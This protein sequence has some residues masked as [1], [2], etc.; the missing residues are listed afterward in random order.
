MTAARP[1]IAI[2]VETSTGETFHYEFQSDRVSIGRSALADVRLPE[3]AISSLHAVIEKMDAAVF[4]VDLGSTNGT[5]L[6]GARLAKERRTALRPDDE[7]TIG[8]FRLRARVV[9]HSNDLTSR[10]ATNLYARRMV[11]SALSRAE[12]DRDAT[13]TIVN[14]PQAG[15]RFLLSG[16]RSEWFLG[17]E[18]SCE[19]PVIDETASRHHAT[20]VSRNG[21]HWVVDVGAKNAVTV[22]RTRV[23]G[24]QRLRDRDEIE[25]GRTRIVFE[26]PSEGLLVAMSSVVDD[27]APD[28]EK[29][30]EPVREIPADDNATPTIQPEPG[31]NNTTRNMKLGATKPDAAA[32][33]RV[34]SRTE[35]I[36]LTLIAA[37]FLVALALTAIVFFGL[38]V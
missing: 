7:V 18:E 23:V 24:E 37:G 13:L 10:D 35:R 2:D 3:T 8:S 38:R 33:R 9:S 25:V 20:V 12:K 11:R 31:E 16:E 32:P 22:N 15:R 29:A 6:S 14:G 21:E 26:D 1:A 36:A 30:G 28:Q 27:A 17:R 19:I 5:R 4:A 34:Y